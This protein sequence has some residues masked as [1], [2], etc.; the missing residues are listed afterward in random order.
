MTSEIS[1]S[2]DRSEA[3][4][5]VAHDRP[6]AMEDFD[7][8]ADFLMRAKQ[9]TAGVDAHADKPQEVAH[10]NGHGGRKRRQHGDDDSH[11]L[12]NAQRHAVGR[13]NRDIFRHHLG[14]DDDHGRH[15]ERGESDALVAEQFYK[16]AGRD[17]RGENVDEVVADQQR[18]D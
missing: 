18:A 14:E 3:I 2:C 9:R 5:V 8:S 12:G 7:R 6:V 1:S 17:C 4:A 13:G 11:R 15:H 16:N 10:E